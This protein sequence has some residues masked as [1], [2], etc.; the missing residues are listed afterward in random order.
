MTRDEA[1]QA[2]KKRAGL[3]AGSQQQRNPSGH[4]GLN[5]LLQRSGER[6]ENSTIWKPRERGDHP[7]IQEV[8]LWQQDEF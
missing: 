3:L 4:G 7:D 8:G 6:R 5:W 2:I 1:Q